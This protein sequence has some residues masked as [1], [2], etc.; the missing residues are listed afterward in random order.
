MTAALPGI[1]LLANV[2]ITPAGTVDL[3]REIEQAGFAGVWIV[4]YEYDATA[5]AQ[6]VASGLEVAVTGTCITRAFT[7]HPISMAETAALIDCLAP[8]RFVIGLGTGPLKAAD[9]KLDRQRWGQE[10]DRPVARMRE[11]LQVLRLALSGEMISYEGEFYDLK[12]IQLDLLPASGHVPI[13]IAAG[14]ERMSQVAGAEADGV[15]VHLANREMTERSL[16]AVAE[17]ARQAGRDAGQIEFSNLIMTCVDEDRDAAYAAMRHYLVDFYLNMPSY[18][19]VIERAGYVDT[20]NTIR[21]RLG[22]G[23][24]AGASD[25]IPDALVDEFTVVGTP[26]EC[27]Q[28]LAEI[29]SWGT[30]MPIV[31]PFPSRGDWLD[32]YRRTLEAFAGIPVAGT[33]E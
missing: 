7:R 1:G 17:G 2:G 13:Y 15:F 24:M 22:S 20:A 30:T 27:E 4:E 33:E 11:Y 21:E 31:Y 32:C 8:G 23:D 9:P 25:S 19:K 29:V 28:K 16:A 3:A 26:E 12:N 5:I 14:G 18:Q 10:W 6:A